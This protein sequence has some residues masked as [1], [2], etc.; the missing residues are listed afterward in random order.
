MRTSIAGQRQR[1]RSPRESLPQDA[2]LFRHGR[3]ARHGTDC[4]SLS[5][6][7]PDRWLHGELL[8][9]DAR[10]P[11]LL[12]NSRSGAR[13]RARLLPFALKLVPRRPIRNVH[14]AG[15]SATARYRQQLTCQVAGPIDLS[16]PYRIGARGG[17]YCT[18]NSR[19]LKKKKF[20]VF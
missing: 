3:C 8:A 12:P 19:T 2:R 7:A 15:E 1:P 14:G 4:P 9:R 11:P 6:P 5:A 20:E 18:G 10:G 13:T 17:T 16:H